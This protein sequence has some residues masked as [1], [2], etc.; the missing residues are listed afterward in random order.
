MPTRF[1][2]PAVAALVPV[3]LLAFAAAPALTAP[4]LVKNN[5]L[6]P[7]AV[8]DSLRQGWNAPP[9]STKP[10]VYWYWLNNIVTKEGITRDLEMMAKNGIGG[11]YIGHIGGFDDTPSNSLTVGYS[12]EWYERMQHAVREGQRLGVQIGVFNGPGWSQSGGPWVKPEQSMQFIDSAELRLSGGSRISQKLPQVKNAVLDVRVLAYPAPAGDGQM[13][14]PLR[15]T[16]SQGA[17]LAQLADGQPHDLPRD[18]DYGQ[19]ALT[20]EFE[21]P[22]TVRSV[23]FTHHDGNQVRGKIS[24][25]EDGNNFKPLRDY[26]LDRRGGDQ[27]ALPDRPSTVSTPPTTARFFHV[28]MPWDT[29]RDGQRLGIQFS[30]AARLEMAEEKQLS[31]ATR[32]NTPDWDTFR[33]PATPEPGAGTV[34]PT[35]VIDLTSKV[36]PD[37]TLDW[38]AP[39]GDWIVQRFSTVSTG[40]ESNPAPKGMEG[41]EIDKM[42]REAARYHIDNG[43]VGE[44]HRR[45]KPTERKGFTWAIAD[46]Y[47][48]GHQ[49]WT[50][51][52]I[53]QFK[54]RYGYDPTPW[55]PVFS[56]R[57]VGSAAQSDRFLWDV[58]RMVADLIS[59]NYVGG[60]RD[61]IHPLGLK[62]WLE[63]YGHWGFPGEFASYGG[64]A[65]GIGGEFWSNVGSL[66][67][68]E[69]RS[70]AAVGHTYGKNIISAEAFTSVGNVFESPGYIKARGDWAFTQGINHFVLHVTSHQP[71]STPGPGLV[72]PWGTYFNT[73]SL[74]FMEHGKAWSDYI[75]RTSYLLQQGRPVADVAYF[76]GEDTP[77]MTGSLN[78]EIPKGYDYDWINS[79]VLLKY[80]TVKNKRLVMRGGASYPVLVLP[81]KAS[82]RPEVLERIAGFVRQGLTVVGAPP[83]ESPSLQNYPAADAKIRALAA[84]L[85]PTGSSA[86]R[87]VGE[88]TVW[89]SAPLAP[90][91][92]GLKVIPPVI[93][94][95]EQ[96]LWKQRSTPDAEIFFLSNQTSSLQSIAPS[97]RATG[98][99][100][101]LWNAESGAVETLGAYREAAGRTVVPITLAPNQSIFVVFHTTKTKAPAVVDV[102]LGNEPALAWSEQKTANSG[103]IA[104]SNLAQSF[105]VKPTGEINLPEQRSGDRAVELSN[106]RW[107]LFPPQGETARGAG[108]A[109]SGVSIGTNGV[110][111]VQHWPFNAP[112][113][114]VWKA[115]QPLTDWTNVLVSYRAGVPHLF[116]NGKEVATGLRTGNRIIAG[117]PGEGGQVVQGSPYEA[118]VRGLKT[119]YSVPDAAAIAALQQSFNGAAASTPLA[120]RVVRA[121]DGKLQ[122]NTNRAGNYT[123]SLHSGK[124]VA[125]KAAAPLPPLALGG[126]WDISFKGAAAPATPSWGAEP[127]V[128]SANKS[129]E[130]GIMIYSSLLQWSELH[131]LSESED[132]A[133]KYFSGNITYETTFNLPASYN[134][135]NTVSTLDL[136]QVEIVARV[137]VNGQAAG[138]ALE[139][140]Y[141]LDISRYLKP[142]KNTLRVLVT[143]TWANRMI[144]DEQFPDDLAA[145]RDGGGNLKEWPKWAYTGEPRPEPRRVT[146]SSRRFFNKGD[147]LPASGLVGPVKLSFESVT[148]I[149]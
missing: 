62:L 48:K 127:V 46:S 36:N 22:Q 41:L 70:S 54:A 107:A 20:W 95:N 103:E 71:T 2:R 58:R 56:G 32:Q 25:S 10:F 148:P 145:V 69:T 130:T 104:D 98:R 29:R 144:G 11:A 50:P 7:M 30:A 101:Q 51:Q 108:F 94:S 134:P 3:S 35:Q 147:R 53:P 9:E 8:P 78:P 106:Q 75:R 133:T 23:L 97:F 15:V 126:P 137:A 57:I 16:S 66:G 89:K 136:G 105:W 88:G 44:L 77:Q 65:D 132:E 115:P 52:M 117:E 61:A 34:A 38:D 128:N 120:V 96:I 6:P 76:I 92:A 39:A 68:M 119:G 143:N 43:L 28:E 26:L 12:D 59:E 33:W 17:E 109:G 140:P 1:V 72:L 142:G 84:S 113:V 21:S 45:L 122:L 131:S 138:T 102:K 73:Q 40:V 129:I 14:K 82:M 125:V 81:A 80:A 139:A 83:T 123:V 5:A 13:L 112:A 124:K 24:Y 149:R 55:L 135:Q 87:K 91:L 31:V 118:N 4:R 27:I 79:E 116:V 49:N 90:I 67:T 86:S 37:G 111:V 63:P 110:V 60:L 74:W 64:Q 93:E 47:E 85:W 42:S 114:L 141:R 146:L 121:A 19:L 18:K 99:A 100:P